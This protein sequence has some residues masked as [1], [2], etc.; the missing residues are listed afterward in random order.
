MEK[1]MFD[2][3]PHWRSI[4]AAAALLC[5]GS[6]ANAESLTV[7]IKGVRSASGEVQL[8]LY[9]VARKHVARKRV[10]ARIGDARVEFGGIAPGAYGVYVY[11]DENGNG[12][13][14]T[15]GLLRLPV[16][17]YAFSN[18]APVR[19]GPPAIKDLRVDLRKGATATTIATMKYRR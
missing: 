6:A 3:K 4:A 12:K 9:D 10:P 8:D 2:R 18:D 14:D 15:G 13:L 5:L 17:G 16:E 19:F 1:L 7:H 11:H